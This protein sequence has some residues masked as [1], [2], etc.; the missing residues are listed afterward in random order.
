MSDTENEKQKNSENK[1]EEKSERKSQAQII[2]EAL[3]LNQDDIEN[4]EKRLFIARFLD[5]YSEEFFDLIYKENKIDEYQKQIESH[6]STL[7]EGTQENVLLKDSY[8]KK[9]IFGVI[10]T[11][12]KNAEELAAKYGRNKPLDKSM[13]MI[14]F[15]ITGVLIG[16]MMVF[17][18]LPIGDQFIW[19]MLPVLCIFC[20]LPQIL[21]GTMMKKWFEFKEKH[22]DEFYKEH[23]ENILILKDF[24][25]QVLD[26]VRAELL[27][28]EVPLQLIKFALHSND[29]ENLKLLNE[30]RVRNSILYYFTFDYPP[31]M[32]PFPIPEALQGQMDDAI[33]QA[34]SADEPPE[35]NFIV[36]TELKA[37]DG[38]IKKF[39]PTLKQDIADEINQMLNECKFENSE[40]DLSEIIPKYS[41]DYGIYCV[42]GELAEIEY[43]QYCTWRDAF[44]F[45]LF[46][47]KPCGC[48][49]KVFALSLIDD[50]DNVPNE[51]KPIF[52]D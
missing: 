46:E 49:E 22:K 10:R 11:L 43:I 41:K 51:L 36:L 31:G 40:R 39:V 27:D 25:A 50:D 52:K 7:S 1:S 32:T 33:A 38:V 30:R 12:N 20:M 28:K 4:V 44:H 19:Y 13:R 48:N 17:F 16:L 2:Q 29:Y 9:D 37:K 47:S 6:L 42:C 18:F 15:I 14:S 35:K 45:Y 3:G 26:N 23:R 8:E 24:T 5:Y 21:R 34:P